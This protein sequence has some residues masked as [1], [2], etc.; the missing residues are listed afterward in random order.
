MTGNSQGISGDFPNE[1]ST[2]FA[3]TYQLEMLECPSN[4]LKAC[5]I[6]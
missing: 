2:I 1:Y 6:A 5:T 3:I 4:P